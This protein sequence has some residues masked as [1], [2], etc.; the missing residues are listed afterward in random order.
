MQVKLAHVK[1]VI[2]F[3]L[4]AGISIALN[5]PPEMKPMLSDYGFFEGKL[6]DLKPAPGVIPYDL[7]T[8][9]FTDYAFKKRFVQLPEGTSATFKDSA[10]FE[11]PVGSVLIKNFYYPKDFRKP[12]EDWQI[13]ETRLLIHEEEGWVALPYIWN[14]DQTDATLEVAG[15]ITDISWKHYNGKKKKLT[16]LVPTMNQCKGCHKQG[17]EFAPIGP[18]ARHLNKDYPYASGMMN[19]LSK[20][21]SEGMLS[22]LPQDHGSI[23]KNA[24]FD[25]PITGNVESRAR[26]WLDINC[27]HCHSKTGPA[28]TSGLFL[29]VFTPNSTALGIRKPPIAAGRASGDQLY[30]IVPGK[31][32]ESILLDRLISNDP[33]IKMP[34]IGRNSVH[35]EGVELVRQWIE[36]MKD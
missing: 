19:Q 15:G 29:D 28:N 36:E 13:I 34:E 20:W 22:G 10:V 2:G 23:Q 25:D 16:Y 26:A 4:V 12:D 7:N 6:A 24:V 5:R 9:L 30:D 21:Q 32:E 14:E 35:Q 27:A 8:P 33:G 3:L 18:A 31:P 17:K 11:F 1:V